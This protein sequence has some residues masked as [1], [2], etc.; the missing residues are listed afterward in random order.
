M[1]IRCAEMQD[2]CGE[3]SPNW[4]AEDKYA[5]ILHWPNSLFEIVHRTLWNFLA[6]LLY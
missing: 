1:L 5:Y 3:L 6:N 2:Y 4:K